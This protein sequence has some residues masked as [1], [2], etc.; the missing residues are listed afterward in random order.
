MKNYLSPPT[1]GPPQS[2]P[3]RE[4]RRHGMATLRA[5]GPSGRTIARR[6]C[7]EI[8]SRA[9][10]ASDLALAEQAEEQNCQDDQT[11]AY[12]EAISLHGEGDDGKEHAG[13]GC[14]DQQKDAKLNNGRCIPGRE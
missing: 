9:C 14:G 7:R 11:D 4:E 8:H 5:G 6:V 3:H 12:I 13:D 10:W 1:G 2:D